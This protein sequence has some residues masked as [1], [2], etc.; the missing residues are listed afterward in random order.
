M[1]AIVDESHTHDRKVAAH[2]HGTDGIKRAIRAGVD[3]IEH[4][5]FLDHEAVQMGID[6]GV[7]FA[8]DIYNTDY[9][10]EQGAANGVPGKTGSDP[11]FPE[12]GSDPFCFCWP[13]GPQSMNDW[14]SRFAATS[15]GIV[16]PRC[17]AIDG[18]MST[19]AGLESNRSLRR[20]LLVTI[21]IVRSRAD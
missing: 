17:L 16:S 20:S 4:A 1:Q 7:Y 10:L 6:R 9:T 14:P 12:M 8:L 3:S 18:R 5:S 13:L 15:C 21:Q 11:V 19:I 2:A